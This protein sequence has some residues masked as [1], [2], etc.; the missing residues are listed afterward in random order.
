MRELQRTQKQISVDCGTC[1]DELCAEKLVNIQL[2]NGKVIANLSS[3]F[4]NNYE[5]IYKLYGSI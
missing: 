2:S 4:D 3:G 5:S 1:L